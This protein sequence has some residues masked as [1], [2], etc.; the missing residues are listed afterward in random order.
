MFSFFNEHIGEV[1][2]DD[3]EKNSVYAVD[4]N[5]YTRLNC[6]LP[7]PLI[8]IGIS[9]YSTIAPYATVKDMIGVFLSLANVHV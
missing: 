3:V 4:E 7:G 8:C 2:F 9:G 6:K 1:H 5:D